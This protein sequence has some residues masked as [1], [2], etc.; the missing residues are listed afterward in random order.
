MASP[1]QRGA[2][3]PLRPG[4]PA[5]FAARGAAP[6]LDGDN[7][8]TLAS[9]L[10]AV[11]PLLTRRLIEEWVRRPPPGEGVPAEIEVPD[12]SLI[13]LLGD[14]VQRFGDRVALVD[15]AH[16]PAFWRAWALST[17]KAGTVLD[18]AGALA[19]AQRAPRLRVTLSARGRS[20]SSAQYTANSSS[21]RVETGKGFSSGPKKAG[22]AGDQ[23]K[24]GAPASCRRARRAIGGASP[25]SATSSALRAKA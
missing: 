4:S 15:G 7:L 17:L 6:G 19:I 11:Q 5:G 12:G 10:L 18:E 24:P 22:S 8:G 21:T 9:S 3:A 14:A 2:A 16:H 25:S 1:R 23:P 20:R 13:D